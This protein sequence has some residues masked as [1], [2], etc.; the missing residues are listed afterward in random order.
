MYSTVKSLVVLWVNFI[1]VRFIFGRVC[2]KLLLRKFSSTWFRFQ[3]C[4]SRQLQCVRCGG[5]RICYIFHETFGRTLRHVDPLGGL[6]QLDIL[7]A[8]RNATVSA[9]ACG[10]LA[11]VTR[12]GCVTKWFVH[13][14][15]FYSNGLMWKVV[16]DCE[17][18]PFA[19]GYS[20]GD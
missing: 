12:C 14:T 11:F 6:T 4:N 5:A 18:D 13:L 19:V 15:N 20:T 3:H 16:A 9:P 10:F 1:F 7:T 8:I 17:R 2:R